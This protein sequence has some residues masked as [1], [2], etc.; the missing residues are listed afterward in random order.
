MKMIKRTNPVAAMV[1]PPIGQ[2]L[3]K[4]FYR[5]PLSESTTYDKRPLSEMWK[6]PQWSAKL[7]ADNVDSVIRSS[8]L[9]SHVASGI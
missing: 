6:N 9:S 1:A 4:D 5:T 3:P 8:R 2:P 7:S